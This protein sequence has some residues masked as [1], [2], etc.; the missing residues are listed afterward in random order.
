MEPAR[1]LAHV[2]D[3]HFGRDAATERACERVRDAL[4][5]ARVDDVLLTG[6]VT[7][8]GRADEWE[9][10]E[11]TF[12]PLRDRTVVVPGNHDRL[13][14]DTAA[15]IMDV[16]VDVASRRGLHVVRVDSTAPHNRG[17]LEGHGALDPA[18]LDAIERA[19]RAAPPGTLAVVALHHHLFPLPPEGIGERLSNWLGWPNASEL[20]RG[21]EL[22]ARLRGICDV[23]AHGH[24]HAE[25]AV[26]FAAR[27]GRPLR[28]M[29][30]GCTPDLG[31]IRIVTHAGGKL[32]SEEWLDV[33]PARL[34]PAA[35]APVPVAA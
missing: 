10:F 26:T 6:D 24:R 2:S 32:L 9:R 33:A 34:R 7:D 11:R 3:L 1:T 21:R 4:L 8:R 30:A 35:R 5:E 20:P 19:V 12:A 25:C 18:D 27:H 14:D 22:L 15:R 16:R 28:V 13:N 31:R 23:V 17:L 29:N